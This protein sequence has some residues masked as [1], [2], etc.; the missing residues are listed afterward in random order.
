MRHFH[1]VNDS[2]EFL[3]SG[4]GLLLHS[5]IKKSHHEAIFAIGSQTGETQVVY[6]T[7]E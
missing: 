3:H 2:F 4:L 6:A 7:I 5:L 1:D